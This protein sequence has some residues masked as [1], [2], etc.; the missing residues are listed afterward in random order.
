MSRRQQPV[1]DPI[2]QLRKYKERVEQMMDNEL[3]KTGFDY[4]FEI[5]YSTMEDDPGITVKSKEPRADL[6]IG[7]LVIFRQF[8]NNDE[9]IQ[10][11][12]V[13]HTLK[14]CLTDEY[15]KGE[16][17]KA[18]KDWKRVM[19]E[20]GMSLIY[21]GKELTPLYLTEM[22]INDTV[23]SSVH[24]PERAAILKHMQPQDRA[25]MR[26]KFFTCL[27]GACRVLVYFHFVITKALDKGLLDTSKM[28]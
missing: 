14:Q 11:S 19:K 4:G 24:D 12:K 27:Q 13:Y 25:I 8:I 26:A 21:N 7:L 5:H 2:E 3:S 1:T 28:K 10:Q 15:L 22:W 23:H 20:D 9:I 16:L 18:M 6:L 17:E